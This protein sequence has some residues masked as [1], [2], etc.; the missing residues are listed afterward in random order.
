MKIFFPLRCLLMGLA[1]LG[2]SACKKTDPEID[3]LSFVDGVP[4]Y[5]FTDNDRF[6]LGTNTGDEWKMEN[7]QGYQRVYRASVIIHD[8]KKARYASPGF[9]NPSKPLAYE[10]IIYVRLARTDSIVGFSELRFYRGAA[11]LTGSPAGSFDPD[12]SEFY[13]QGEWDDFVGNSDPHVSSY[14]CRGLSM[15]RGAALNGPFQQLT[16]RG[17]AYNE[18]MAFIGNIRDPSCR[19]VSSSFMQALYYDR[20]VGMVRMVSLA[21]EV[22]DRV[23]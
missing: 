2:S 11:K 14:Y 5:H 19:P 1:L 13:A 3:G 17:R 21:G 9:I 16:V 23:P 8:I 6:W 20:Q 4:Y 22:W 7:A 15:P 18:V 10:D 12:K